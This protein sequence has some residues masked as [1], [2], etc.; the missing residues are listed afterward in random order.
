MHGA[1]RYDY[2][3]VDNTVY[4]NKVNNNICAVYSNNKQVRSSVK[5][6]RIP[7]TIQLTLDVVLTNNIQKQQKKVKN[8]QNNLK[9]SRAKK[10]HLKKSTLLD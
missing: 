7:S 8:K 9:Q 10:F 2:F 1:T 4:M 5:M 6:P 3:V